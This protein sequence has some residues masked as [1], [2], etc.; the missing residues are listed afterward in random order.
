MPLV[1]LFGP[2]CCRLRQKDCSVLA[3]LGS[4]KQFEVVVGQ[5]GRLWVKASHASD[6]ILVANALLASEHMSEK[7]IKAMIQRITA[8]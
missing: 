8:Q 6:T 5:N 7:Q 1:L 4:L 2:F 3:A